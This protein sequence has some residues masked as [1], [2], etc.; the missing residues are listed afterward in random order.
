VS[1]TDGSFQAGD[2]HYP[3]HERFPTGNH[4]GYHPGLIPSPKPAGATEG[5]CFISAADRVAY[6]N[7]V[8]ALEVFKGHDIR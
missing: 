7:A 5:T 4:Q 1:C 6:E 8:N 2:F 3:G